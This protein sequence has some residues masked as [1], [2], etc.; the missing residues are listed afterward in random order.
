MKAFLFSCV[1]AALTFA[2]TPAAFALTTSSVKVTVPATRLPASAA[3]ASNYATQLLLYEGESSSRSLQQ[4]AIDR[5][6]AMIKTAPSAARSDQA[7]Y[8]ALVEI[9]L[10]GTEHPVIESSVVINSY[11]L[12][13]MQA[14]RELGTLGGAQAVHDLMRVI[15]YE[16]D[17]VV[18]SEIAYQ[19]G[20]LGRNPNNE[21]ADAI[22]F[23]LRRTVFAPGESIFAYSALAAFRVLAR[24]TGNDPALFS[25]ISTLRRVG[26]DETVR[27]EAASLLSA[28]SAAG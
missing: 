2:F 1:V 11:P 19:L 23:A 16:N 7:V 6:G 20:R 14:Y 13:R 21:A 28:L 5:V 3:Q 10:S 27:R 8:S 22:V 18:L 26:S 4:D 12:L 15:G 17:P 9:A 25:E 24:S